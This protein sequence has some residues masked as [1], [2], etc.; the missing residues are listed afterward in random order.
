MLRKAEEQRPNFH[1]QTS[2]EIR[3]ENG[4]VQRFVRRKYQNQ[5]G[6]KDPLGKR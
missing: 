4:G 2:K 3:S 5:G 1:S 6:Q